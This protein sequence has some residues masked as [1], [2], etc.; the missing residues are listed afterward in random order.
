MACTLLPAPSSAPN[1]TMATDSVEAIFLKINPHAPVLS[2]RRLKTP[3]VTSPAAAAI[4]GLSERKRRPSRL[5][6][7]PL[8][9]TV[10]RVSMEPNIAHPEE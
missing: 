1:A 3:P 8:Y 6:P 9:A 4:T 5:P 10:K 2:G 7:A